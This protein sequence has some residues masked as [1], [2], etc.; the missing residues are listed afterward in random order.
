MGKKYIIT[1]GIWWIKRDSLFEIFIPEFEI[2]QLALNFSHVA[3]IY[4]NIIVAIYSW[5]MG[6][7]IIELVYNYE[8]SLYLEE[9][10]AA[11]DGDYASLKQPTH[12]GKL[13]SCMKQLRHYATVDRSP[14]LESLPWRTKCRC[15]WTLTLCIPYQLRRRKRARLQS[16]VASVKWGKWDI[17]AVLFRM[18]QC[19][20][21]IKFG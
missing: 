4:F 16:P 1:R 20:K 7:A 14:G 9:I 21:D 2:P 5:I 18:T 3:N 17:S 15:S 11:L 10:M 19:S 6:N 12:L 8:L 13:F